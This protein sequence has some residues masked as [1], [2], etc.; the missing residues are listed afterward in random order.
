MTTSELQFIF[1]KLSERNKSQ[2]TR[3]Q[4]C[5]SFLPLYPLVL[6]SVFSLSSF[7]TYITSFLYRL[8]FFTMVPPPTSSHPL[9]SSI[10]S[11]EVASNDIR[12][13]FGTQAWVNLFLDEQLRAGL[14]HILGAP[15]YGQWVKRC[16][17]PHMAR[18]HER[19]ED[20]DLSEGDEEF[21]NL[22]ESRP[23]QR[24]NL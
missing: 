18:D 12:T 22:S 14:G 11:P 13:Q 15:G 23:D 21:L 9:P 17:E 19:D 3:G 10:S 1:N 5:S 7:H 2:Y 24:T 8:L 4:Y 16:L 6:D 20:E